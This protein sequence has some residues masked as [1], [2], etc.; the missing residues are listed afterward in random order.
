M[1]GR[2]LSCDESTYSELDG[3]TACVACPKGTFAYIGWSSCTVCSDASS[4]VKQ[5]YYYISYQKACA[6][7]SLA[8]LGQWQYKML[9]VNLFWAASAVAVWIG[10]IAAAR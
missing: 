2:C 7:L 3:A 9:N 10:L 1:G 5:K 6:S 4:D 8:A